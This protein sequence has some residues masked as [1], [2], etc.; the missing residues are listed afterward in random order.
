MF[1]AADFMIRLQC[2]VV[3]T[4]IVLP[5]MIKVLTVPRQEICWLLIC[6]FPPPN[7]F[8]SHLKWKIIEDK[9]HIYFEY[10]AWLWKECAPP[11]NNKIT[12]YKL[13]I[14]LKEYRRETEIRRRQLGSGLHKVEVTCK[15]YS[16]RSPTLFVLGF[17]S[18]LKGAQVLGTNAHISN[19]AF[20]Q[21]NNL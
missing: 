17:A 3:V 12:S 19:S 6:G 18:L 7:S 13:H 10:Q 9:Y 16:P 5:T 21:H 15:V 4:K 11:F 14:L 2:W 20:Y 1:S 8:S